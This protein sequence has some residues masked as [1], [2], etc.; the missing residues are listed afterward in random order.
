MP[1][2]Y[3]YPRPSVTVDTV[4]FSVIADD[5]KVLLIRRGVEPFK[6]AWAIPGG[7]VG[8]DESLEDAARR[9]LREE[10]NVQ[11]V[12]MEQLYTFGAPERDPRGRT[13]TVAYFALIAADQREIAAA[14]DSDAVEWF[15]VYNLPPLAFDHAS[16]VEYA[17]TRL[18]FKLDYTSVGFQLLPKKFTLTELQAMYEVILARKLDKRNFRKKVLSM[19]ILE[20]LEETKMEGP[21]RPAKLYSFTEDE[22]VAWPQHPTMG[23]EKGPLAGLMGRRS[24]GA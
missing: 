5:L 2:T 17:L 3:E 6:G 1:H 19:G 23:G 8:M 11:G 14:T 20:P 12:Y 13:I 4:I 15:S 7:F 24:D 10:T 16:I 22:L 9:E 21:H 18:R